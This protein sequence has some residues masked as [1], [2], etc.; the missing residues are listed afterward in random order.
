MLINLDTLVSKTGQ[1]CQ[2]TYSKEVK[3]L[4]D[5]QRNITKIVSLNCRAG[6]EYDNIKDVKI[7]RS[8][9]ELPDENQGLPW[10]KWKQYPYLIEHKGKDYVRVALNKNSKPKTQYFLGGQEITR[11]EALEYALASEKKTGEMPDVLTIDVDKIL[12]I[13]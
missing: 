11:E 6:I 4:K 2:V 5:H 3:Q 8:T 10:G 1:Y 9:G 7:K 12:S 13:T